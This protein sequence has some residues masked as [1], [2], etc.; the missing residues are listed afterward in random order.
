MKDR[1]DFYDA[2][3]DARQDVIDYVKNDKSID[4]LLRRELE[5]AR[6]DEITPSMY[7]S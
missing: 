7:S 1:I 6:S 4:P 2:F 5:C 3:L